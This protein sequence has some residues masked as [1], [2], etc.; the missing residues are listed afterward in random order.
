MQGEQRADILGDLFPEEFK[1][2]KLEIVVSARQSQIEEDALK[3]CYDMT[4]DINIE[5]KKIRKK[6]NSLSPRS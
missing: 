3:L 5:R 1:N 4:R 2:S 6:P